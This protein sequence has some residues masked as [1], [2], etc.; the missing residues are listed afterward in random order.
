MMLKH[1]GERSAALRIENAV[2][3]VYTE[4]KHTTRDVGGKS[5]TA[6]FTNAIIAA[7]APVPAR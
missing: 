5:G 2:D 6:D 4:A 1:L 7:L 3:K